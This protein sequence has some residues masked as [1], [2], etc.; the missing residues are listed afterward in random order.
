[1]QRLNDMPTS[2]LITTARNY[3]ASIKEIGVYS[4]LV[5]QL[6]DRLALSTAATSQ[7]LTERADLRREVTAYEATV[8]NLE[9]QV[10]GLLSNQHLWKPEVCPVTLRP[11]FLWIESPGG[12]MVPTYG[13]PY[14]SYTI[15]VA[16]KDGEFSCERFDHDEGAWVDDICLNVRLIDD[17]LE[18]LTDAALAEIRNEARAS[19][20]PE[21]FVLVP[22]QIFLDASDIESICSQCGDGGHNYG[23][24]SDG[25]LWV[26][27][28]Q[29]DD[30]SIVHG[31][32]ISSADY[33]EEGGITVCEF[34]Q[35]LR[36]EQGK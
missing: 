25:L 35:Q 21:G 6:T 11:F 19:V 16:N 31:L 18:I 7:A 15:P 27:D 3:S 30:G 9:A 23:D 34:A 28:I 4:E 32:H 1:M 22:Q 12:E 36:K 13:G 26:G 24:F 33:P 14:D 20:I 29:K 8:T 5:K 2:E 10:Q 17:Q